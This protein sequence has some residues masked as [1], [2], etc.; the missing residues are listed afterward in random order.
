M[1][2]KTLAAL[3]PLFLAARAFAGDAAAGAHEPAQNHR[4]L[5]ERTFPAGA[6]DG[7]DE[8]TKAKVNANNASVGVNWVK[9]YANAD[10]T[11]TFCIYEGP[12]EEA[13]R[14]AAALNQLPVDSIVE[15]PVDLTP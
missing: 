4:Y 8:A 7:L 12:S 11:K 14:Q 6:L 5:I 3:A 10:R 1:K 15:V 13:V 9:S 2:T